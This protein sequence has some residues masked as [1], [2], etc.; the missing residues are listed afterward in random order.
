V[1]HFDRA[2]DARDG[3]QGGRVNKVPFQQALQRIRAEYVEMPGMR[4]TPEQ[5]ERL[6]G[7]DRSVCRQVLDT[8]VNAQFLFVGRDGSYTRA[9]T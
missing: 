1:R 6:S 9:G 8:L 3:S 4:L 7:L 2:F 5:V